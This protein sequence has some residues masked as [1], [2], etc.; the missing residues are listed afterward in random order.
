M[1]NLEIFIKFKL[2]ANILQPLIVAFTLGIAVW[3]NAYFIV[4]ITTTAM[5][6]FTACTISLQLALLDIEIDQTPPR[7]RTERQRGVQYSNIAL[8]YLKLISSAIIFGLL[9]SGVFIK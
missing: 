9:T 1:T 4:G 5:V 8:G 2:L 3:T 7:E 6:Y